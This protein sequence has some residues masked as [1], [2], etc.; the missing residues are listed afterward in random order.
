MLGNALKALEPPLLVRQQAFETVREAIITGRLAP[1]SRLIEREL[2]AALGISRASVREVIRRLEAERLISMKPRHGPTVITLTAKEAAEI[3]EIRG[4]IES[5][6]FRRFTEKAT[7]AEIDTLSAIFAEV[8]VA[9]AAEAVP[10][11]VALISRFNAHLI[12]VVDNNLARDLLDQLN[13]RIAWLRVK[14]MAEPGR[15]AASIAELS[16]VIEAV[17]ARDAERAVREIVASVA[18]ASKAAFEHLP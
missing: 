17:R 12:A 1:G 6:L 3:Y 14:A 13:A 8:K 4:M 11:I 18:N 10:D 16:R 9:A 5:L 15:I 2:C 7:D